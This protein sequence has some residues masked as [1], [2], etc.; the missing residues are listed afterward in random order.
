MPRKKYTEG[1][2]NLVMKE[3]EN[4]VKVEELCR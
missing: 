2:I 4:G 3:L 1:R